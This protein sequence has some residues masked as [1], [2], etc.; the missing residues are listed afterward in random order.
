MTKPLLPIR[1]M[2]PPIG[3]IP[4]MRDRQSGA[5]SLQGEEGEG[6]GCGAHLSRGRR[7]GPRRL[8]LRIPGLAAG[9]PADEY[10]GANQLRHSCG[11]PGVIVR[12]GQLPH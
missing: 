10:V 6:Q 12:K 4:R 3:L 2:H 5:E 11:E 7:V 9:I 8:L 1:G